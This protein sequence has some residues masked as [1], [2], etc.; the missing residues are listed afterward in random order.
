MSK[1][2]TNDEMI[3]EGLEELKQIY[4]QEKEKN[5]I[6]NPEIDHKL[7]EIRET[8][9]EIKKDS[10]TD[11]ELVEK[12]LRI[13]EQQDEFLENLDNIID[14]Y[15]EENRVERAES[16]HDTRH[17]VIGVTGGIIRYATYITSSRDKEE[18]L[19][20]YMDKVKSHASSN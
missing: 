2:L 8:A 14:T 10:L 15:E 5:D 13:S 19:E 20:S 11:Q 16:K 7:T 1:P 18:E 9:E 17:Q 4:R 12:V 3:K 6:T